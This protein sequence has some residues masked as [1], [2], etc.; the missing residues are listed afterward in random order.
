MVTDAAEATGD[1]QLVLVPSVVKNLELW[2]VCEG[3]SALNAVLAVVC[4]VPPLVTASVPASV[5]APEVAVLGVKPVVPA[6]NVVTALVESVAQVGTP[7]AT[8]ST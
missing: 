1:A 4:P 5:M 7:P 3:A 6:L 2:L 8:V